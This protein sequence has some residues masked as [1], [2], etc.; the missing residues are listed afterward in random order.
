MTFQFQA[1]LL[2]QGAIILDDAT[3]RIDGVAS[4]INMLAALFYETIFSFNRKYITA[5]IQDKLFYDTGQSIP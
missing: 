1:T 5:S 3:R 4:F 2:Q